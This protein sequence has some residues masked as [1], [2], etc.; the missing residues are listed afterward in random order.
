MLASLVFQNQGLQVFSVFI[1]RAKSLNLR[2]QVLFYFFR[3]L[4]WRM[5]LAAAAA[6]LDG[7][8]FWAFL[9][10]D[11][12]PCGNAFVVI[13]FKLPCRFTVAQLF[14]HHGFHDQLLEFQR[15][16]LVFRMT[17]N[18]LKHEAKKQEWN[19]AIQECRSSGLSV[20]EWCR[21]QGVTTTLL[22]SFSG[23]PLSF[24]EA[25]ILPSK[26]TVKMLRSGLKK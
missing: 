3:Q 22:A 14:F 9:Q 6:S 1:L 4:L 17:S 11:S 12:L 26:K 15:I 18:E 21:Q 10:I 24:A 13:D 2:Q 16:S 20:S 19:I 23:I 25:Q 7:K 8:A 5:A